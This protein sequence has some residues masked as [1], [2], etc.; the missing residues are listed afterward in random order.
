MD[1]YNFYKG[2]NTTAPRRG[3]LSYLFVGIIGAVIGGFLVLTFAPAALLGKVVPKEQ[4]AEP[5][6]QNVIVPQTTQVPQ[7]TDIAKKVMPAVVGVRTAKYEKGM[8]FGN[9]KVEGIGSGVIVDKKGYILT[10]NHVADKKSASIKVSLSDGRIVPAKV[11]WTDEELDL[12]ILKIDADNLT[13]AEIGNSDT[14]QVGELAVAIGNPLGLSFQRSAAS[15]I[16]SALNRY[17]PVGDDK[18]MEDLIQTNASINDDNSG[19]PLIN[20][21]GK[22]IGINTKKA[23]GSD[24]EGFAIPINIAVPVIKSFAES[25]SFNTPYMGI[26]GLDRDIANFYDYKINKGIYIANIDKNGPAYKAGV[27]KGEVILAVNGTDTN[28]MAALDQII[29]NAGVNSQVNV[30]YEDKN[31]SVKDISI[32]LGQNSEGR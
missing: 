20:S 15:G 9:K 7:I 10:N 11:L 13:V 1:N 28:T 22:V 30:K 19:G 18:F 23:A 31:G 27:R 8:F 6:T 2:N 26:S 14:L 21:D 16:V 5:Q 4:A 25:G 24:G 12:S 17:I 32:T 3:Y 29:F